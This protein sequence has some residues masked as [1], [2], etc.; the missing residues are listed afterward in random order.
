MIVKSKE[1]LDRF[2]QPGRCENC[3]IWCAL[4]RVSAHVF[5]R[6]HGGGT[7]LDIALNLVSLGDAFRCR[8]HQD[9]HSG[10]L[11]TGRLCEIVGQR[12]GMTGPEVEA[13]LR[14][15]LRAPKEVTAC[16]RCEGTGQYARYIGGCEPCAVCDGQGL[17]N[18]HGEPW[19]EQVRTFH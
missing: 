15:M 4:P 17:L 9:H 13:R 6:G 18:Q 10:K 16:P 11:K 19:R 2:R 12:Y 1:T 14:L 5:G 7:R 3:D 8:C